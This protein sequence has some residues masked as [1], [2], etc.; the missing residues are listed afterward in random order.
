M[1]PLAAR[2][3]CVCEAS[4]DY[5]VSE[6]EELQISLEFQYHALQHADGGSFEHAGSNGMKNPWTMVNVEKQNKGIYIDTSPTDTNT[7]AP[8]C[9]RGDGPGVFVSLRLVS[10]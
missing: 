6:A 8:A 9:P 2:V 4:F 5:F 7:L 10:I 1:L 3:D